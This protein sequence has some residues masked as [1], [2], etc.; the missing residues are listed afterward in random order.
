MLENWKQYEG[1]L[2]DYRIPEKFLQENA[3]LLLAGLTP[4]KNLAIRQEP[5]SHILLFRLDLPNPV[6]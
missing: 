6:N 2:Y 5:S 3:A 4:E 1:Q